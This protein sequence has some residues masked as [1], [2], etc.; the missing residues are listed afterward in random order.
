M[1]DRANGRRKSQ[2]IAKSTVEAGGYLDY[3]VNKTNYKIAYTDF[4]TGLGVTGTIVQDGAVTGTPILDVNGAVNQIRNLENGPGIV[5]SV[6]A[7]NGAKISHNFTASA[8]G[9]PV[10]LN[11]TSASPTIASIVAG[12]GISIATVNSSGI[13]IS[14]IADAIY[15]QLTIH[16]NSTNTTIGTAGTAVLVAGTWAAGINSSF[17]LTT[18]GRMT[19]TGTTTEVVSVVAS[20]TLLPASGV[21]QTLTVYIAKD[22]VVIPTAKI[23]RTVSSTESAN[24]SLAFN[25]S[26]ANNDYIEL[27]VANETSTNDVLVTDALFGVS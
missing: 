22:G 12:S 23:S 20:V 27:F 13:E 10:L 1:A 21:N 24:V 19:Y 3:V 15:G 6:S 18:A 11:T 7:D 8:D 5:T 25:L 2:F 14:S 4:V 16:G 26:L 9:F 17:T